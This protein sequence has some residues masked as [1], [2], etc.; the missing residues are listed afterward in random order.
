M[1]TAMLIAVSLAK[2]PRS[3]VFLFFII[4]NDTCSE[5]LLPEMSKNHAQVLSNEMVSL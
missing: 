2:V 5:L 4:K 3:K 1:E